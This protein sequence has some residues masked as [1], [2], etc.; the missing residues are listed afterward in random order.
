[1]FASR[2]IATTPGGHRYTSSAK[3]K[4]T[5]QRNRD[6]NGRQFE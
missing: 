2:G 1:M 3:F 5:R 4:N 6:E